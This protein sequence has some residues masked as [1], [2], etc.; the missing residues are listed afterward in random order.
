MSFDPKARFSTM[1]EL[2]RALEGQP[3]KSR[4]RPL[5]PVLTTLAVAAT[6]VLGWGLM[7]GGPTV[8]V[9]QSSFTYDLR[10][11]TALSML[12]SAR[13]RAIDGDARTALNDLLGAAELMS[14]VDPESDPSYC[15]FGDKLPDIA[16]SM[17]AHGGTNEARMVYGIALRF[18]QDCPGISRQ[19]LMA[20]RESSRSVAAISQ[21]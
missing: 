18:S 15:E 1:N 12:D 11:E 7:P 21:P 6:F 13:K 20:R 5:R 14:V 17:A 16:D 8:D 10:G 2:L 3:S 9:A 4:R 19:D